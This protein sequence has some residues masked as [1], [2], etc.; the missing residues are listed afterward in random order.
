[1]PTVSLML[2]FGR[3]LHTIIIRANS[4][5]SSLSST[6]FSFV[7][8]FI[9]L[10][11]FKNIVDTMIAMFDADMDIAMFNAYMDAASLSCYKSRE[12]C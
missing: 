6:S 2:I 12:P 10:K 8:T 11:Q 1:M 9:N 7:I 3:L 4:D 5:L